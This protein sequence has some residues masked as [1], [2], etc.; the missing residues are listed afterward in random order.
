MKLTFTTYSQPGT[1]FAPDAFTSNVGKSFPVKFK[2]DVVGTATAVGFGVSADGL[3]VETTI[4]IDAT[5]DEFWR[6]L[7]ITDLE[8]S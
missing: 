6:Q 1:V 3:A 5:D 8:V 2:G 7:Q 4:D